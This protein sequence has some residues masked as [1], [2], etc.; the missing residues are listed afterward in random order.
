MSIVLMQEA[1]ICSYQSEQL[2][3]RIT[4]TFFHDQHLRVIMVCNFTDYR[5]IN[6][7]FHIID[8]RNLI[9]HDFLQQDKS[10]WQ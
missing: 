10:E 8:S 3:Y 1:Q 7:C 4:A 6:N 5:H 9:V 2:R